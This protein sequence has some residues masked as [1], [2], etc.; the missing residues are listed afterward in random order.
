MHDSVAY[1]WFH[2]FKTNFY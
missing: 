1:I 2:I